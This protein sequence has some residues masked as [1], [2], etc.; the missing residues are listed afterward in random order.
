M[1]GAEVLPMRFSAV[2]LLMVLFAELFV[3]ARIDTR[4]T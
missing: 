3:F 2:P 1:R 4:R